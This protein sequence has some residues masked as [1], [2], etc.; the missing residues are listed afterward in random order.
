VLPACAARVGVEPAGAVAVVDAQALAEMM[1]AA[2]INVCRPEPD[3]PT[4]QRRY[5][6]S[7]FIAFS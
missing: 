3:R 7:R 6:A 1:A 5:A 4:G 2:A